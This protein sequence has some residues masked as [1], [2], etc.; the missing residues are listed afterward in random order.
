VTSRAKCIT[1]A[2]GIL[3]FGLLALI[4]V[5]GIEGEMFERWLGAHELQRL[6][7]EWIKEGQPEPSTWQRAS[8]DGRRGKL[9]VHI[10]HY[11]TPVRDYISLFRYV[12]DH[13]KHPLAI[14]KD[15][16]ILI[17][18][19]PSAIRTIWMHPKKAAAW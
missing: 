2:V 14:T 15:G 18:K 10:D 9:E 19:N 17:L 11:K 5:L 8:W 3:A 12:D 6:R 4:T 1:W 13:R 16:D 7:A